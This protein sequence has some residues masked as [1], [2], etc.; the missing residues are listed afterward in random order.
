VIVYVAWAVAAVDVPVIAP[1][2]A[3]RLRPAGKSGLIE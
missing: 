3:F 2:V 1:V